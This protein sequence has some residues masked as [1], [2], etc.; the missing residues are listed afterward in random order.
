[1]SLPCSKLYKLPSVWYYPWNRIP[2]LCLQGHKQ[3]NSLPTSHLTA[4][5]PTTSPAHSIPAAVSFLFFTKH[6]KL[7]PTE[8]PNWTISMLSGFQ[9][10][11]AITVN[12]I[13][14]IYPLKNTDSK[15]ENLPPCYISPVGFGSQLV[16]SAPRIW[17]QQLD[18]FEGVSLLLSCLSG[19]IPLY[20]F[21]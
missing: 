8:E 12:V 17:F 19:M 20:L 5:Q 21:H 11:W 4:L 14:G 13:N 9:T 15:A 7:I 3:L 1:M 16:W 6:N 2:H 10:V 18:N